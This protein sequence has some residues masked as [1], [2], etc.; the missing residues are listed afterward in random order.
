M[1]IKNI[2]LALSAYFLRLFAKQVKLSVSLDKQF[3][4]LTIRFEG[5][6]LSCSSDN[7]IIIIRY[8]NKYKTLS[9][10][11]HFYVNEHFISQ[12]FFTQ[13]DL[14]LIDNVKTIIYGY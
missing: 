9:K 13:F 6:M 4:Y 14:T 12:L 7:D 3:D 5:K 1:N 8:E 2:K 11:Q 10:Y